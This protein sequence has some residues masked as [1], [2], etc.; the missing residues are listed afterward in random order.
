MGSRLKPGFSD[1]IV[2]QFRCSRKVIVNQ[3]VSLLS[4]GV[5]CVKQLLD[6]FQ[7]DVAQP[8]V[9]SLVVVTKT[10]LDRTVF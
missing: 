5:S 3:F 1:D 6:R 4:V 8:L 7:V 9:V 10:E 2:E